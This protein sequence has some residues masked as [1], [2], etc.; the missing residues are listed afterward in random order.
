MRIGI[1]HL[2]GHRLARMSIH[3]MDA[4]ADLVAMN[5]ALDDFP[6]VVELGGVFSLEIRELLG[7]FDRHVLAPFGGKQPLVGGVSLVQLQRPLQ[8][9]PKTFHRNI[10][11]RLGLVG[12]RAEAAVDGHVRIQK[13][14]CHRLVVIELKEG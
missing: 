12:P 11:V 6:L 8:G 9:S 7:D 10:G 14:S 2:R 3:Q 13:E 1:K 5:A 4:L